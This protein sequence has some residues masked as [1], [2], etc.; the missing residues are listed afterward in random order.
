MLYNLFQVRDESP[1][2]VYFYQVG[3]HFL[4]TAGVPI[5]RIPSTLLGSI[6]IPSLE[7]MCPNNFP[8]SIPKCDFFGF[9]DM[10]NFLHF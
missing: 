10:S 4:F 9:S 3:L 8:Y 7:I 1:Q 2:E 5:F 6:L